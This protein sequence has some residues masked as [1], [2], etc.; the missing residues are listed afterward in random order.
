MSFVIVKYMG[1]AFIAL[2][3][4][5]AA[6]HWDQGAVSLAWTLSLL[7]GAAFLLSALAPRRAAAVVLLLALG[8]L[9]T[10]LSA[11]PLP[12]PG[13][14][15]LHDGLIAAAVAAAIAGAAAALGAASSLTLSRWSR[16]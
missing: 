5:L 1:L 16:R 8:V 3:A 6:G 13:A 9:A 12:D 4:G 10:H 7:G 11:A 15:D 2:S 14:S